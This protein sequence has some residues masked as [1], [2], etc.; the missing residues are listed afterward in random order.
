MTGARKTFVPAHLGK[1]DCARSGPPLWSPRMTGHRFPSKAWAS[2][3]QD[4]LNASAAYAEA[5]RDWTHGAVAMVVK[6]DEAL[7]LPQNMAILLDVDSGKCRAAEYMPASEVGERANFVI[8]GLYDRWE[9][10][11][12]E[13]GDPIKALM[14]GKLKMTKGH[15]PTII[16]YVASSKALLACAQ[17]VPASFR[18][19]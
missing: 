15:L 12:R 10:L 9:S 6:A 16:R 8:E 13:G 2:A 3:Y 7:E 11:I 14:Q 4:V 19:P 1:G 5:G 17:E 18:T